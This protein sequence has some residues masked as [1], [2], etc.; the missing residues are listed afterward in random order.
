MFFL[1]HNTYDEKKI[2]TTITVRIAAM[3]AG[4]ASYQGIASA[5]PKKPDFNAPLGAAVGIPSLPAGSFHALDSNIP[6]NFV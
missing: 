1:A 4:D 3:N 2:S 6:G 5:M